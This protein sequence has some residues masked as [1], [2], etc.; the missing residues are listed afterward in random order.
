MKLMNIRSLIIFLSFVCFY[1]QA[2]AD[3]ASNLHVNSGKRADYYHLDF[4]LTPENALRPFGKNKYGGREF[5]LIDG[6]FEVLIKKEHFPISSKANG[7]HLI[8][9]MPQNN[10]PKSKVLYEKIE[11]MFQS[12]SGHVDVV[13][14]L[15]PYVEILS[16]SPLKLVLTS[17]N[18]F[19]RTARGKYINHTKTL[20]H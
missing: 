2:Y 9:R 11:K 18:I 5:K 8:L 12:K 1:N 7:K 3:L 20:K 16:K 4:K 15:N 13:V 14:E 10:D 19:F 6:Q 17:N